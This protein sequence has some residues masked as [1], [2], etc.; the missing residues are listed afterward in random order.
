VGIYSSHR[1]FLLFP[2]PQVVSRY[3]SAV[4]DISNMGLGVTGVAA[5]LARDWIPNRFNTKI[6]VATALSTIT[7]TGGGNYMG[8]EVNF[9]AKYNL[10]VFLTAGLSAAYL[11][12]GDFYDA[13]GVT[14]TDITGRPDDPWTVFLSLSWLMF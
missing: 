13:P 5:N 3:Y 6:G 8:T 10:A 12:L 2:D 14:P 11:K 7:P 1:A 9:E 4:H